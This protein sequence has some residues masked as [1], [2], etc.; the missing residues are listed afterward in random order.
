[1][2]INALNNILFFKIIFHFV[3]AIWGSLMVII[4]YVLDKKLRNN[5]LINLNLFLGKISYSIYLFHLMTIYMI[6][7][8]NFSLEIKILLFLTLQIIISSILYFYF[9]KPILK[10]RPNY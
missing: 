7:P 1:M 9:E 3:V 4:F 6:S 2:E 8:L 5:N 10:L